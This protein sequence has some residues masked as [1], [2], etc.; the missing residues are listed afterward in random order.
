[1]TNNISSLA[2]ASYSGTSSSYEESS[3]QSSS[4]EEKFETIYKENEN[5][6]HWVNTN[7]LLGIDGFSGVKTGITEAAGPCL[8]CSFEK[9]GHFL[10][11]ILLQSKSMEARW[12]EAQQLI[13]WAVQRRQLMAPIP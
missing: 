5:P 1:M 2:A 10:I 7:R 11:V 9:D 4:V 12:E 8:A 13:D 6:Y 3:E